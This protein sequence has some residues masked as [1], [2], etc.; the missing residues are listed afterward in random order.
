[1]LFLCLCYFE[2]DAPARVGKASGRND[3]KNRRLY[4]AGAIIMEG[5]IGSPDLGVVIRGSGDTLEFA[6]GPFRKADA[7][8]GAFFLVH[9]GTIAEAAE[10]VSN[11]PSI[12][13]R[14][15]R[16]RGIEVRPIDAYDLPGRPN[17]RAHQ[18][19][20]RRSPFGSYRTSL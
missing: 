18:A 8:V 3:R 5:D 10:I 9:A 7:Q 6:E 20:S 17:G 12:H 4:G 1:M 15:R 14:R 2:G 19:A 13:R 11:H 16:G